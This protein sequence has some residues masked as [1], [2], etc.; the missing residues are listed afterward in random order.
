[1]LVGFILILFGACAAFFGYQ[2][3]RFTVFFQG[4]LAGAVI[5]GMVGRGFL[6]SLLLGLVFGAGLGIMAVCLLRLGVFLQ[7]FVCAFGILFIPGI[8]RKIMGLL[9]W[10]SILKLV[11]DYI[12]TGEIDIDFREELIVSVIVGV[13][14]GIIG[15]VFTRIMITL[16]SALAG[17]TIAGIGVITALKGIAPQLAVIMGIILAVSGIL[18]QYF[19]W[20]KKNEAGSVRMVTQ[21]A[22]L[23]DDMEKQH[24]MEP[25]PVTQPIQKEQMQDTLHYCG[26]CGTQIRGAAKFCPKCGKQQ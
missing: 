20:K 15:L 14:V 24:T 16:V 23:P 26:H 9:N 5:G 7:C 18:Y 2:M 1:M 21:P 10:P 8:I 25:L 6:L 19:D 13:I 11:R 12:F 17:G 3:Y 22:A 4:F